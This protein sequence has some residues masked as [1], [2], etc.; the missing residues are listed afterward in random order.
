MQRHFVLFSLLLIGLLLVNC[1]DSSNVK[2]SKPLVISF[3]KE[4]TLQLKKAANDS[5][6]KSLDIEIADDDYQI[7]TGLMYRDSMK[8]RQGMLFLFPNEAPRSF[9][10]KNTRIPLDIIYIAA[11]S[12]IVSFQK[13]TEPFN[14]TSLPSNAPAKYVLEI[15]GGLAD[16]WQLEV[17]DKID[18]EILN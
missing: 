15:N 8:K 2:E 10:M 1:K 16:T 5:V 6:I 4:G 13:N 9:Y 17:G 12:S 7:Q 18:F 11:D 14:E 3:K